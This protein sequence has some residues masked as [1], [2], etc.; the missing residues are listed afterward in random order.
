MPDYSLPTLP[1]ESEDWLRHQLGE[2]YRQYRA[3]H[4]R[5][6]GLLETTPEGQTHDHHDPLALA[7]QAES[8]ALA[9]YMWLLKIV[10]DLMGYSGKR[11]VP[12]KVKASGGSDG[13]FNF[14]R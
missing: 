9:D 3:A 5:Y 10:T 6:R 11:E 2:A 12:L 8:E 7:R 14:S 1:Q 4:A 13:E